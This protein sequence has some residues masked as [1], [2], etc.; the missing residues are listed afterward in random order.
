LLFELKCQIA[1]CRN[2]MGYES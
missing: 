1:D 2:A